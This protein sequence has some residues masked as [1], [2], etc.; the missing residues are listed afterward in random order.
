MSLKKI[1]LYDE[2]SIAE[3]NIQSLV[4]FLKKTIPVEVIVKDNFFS[5]FTSEQIYKISETRIF[6]I[7]KKFEYY[8]PN[9]CDLESE[10]KFCSNSK[11]M[12]ETMKP[13][14]ASSISD[15]V[16]YDGFEMQKIIRNQLAIDNQTLHIILTNRFTCT[17]DESDS[18]YH[19]RAVICANPAIIST[20]GIVEAPAK[21]KKFYIEAMA[22][23]AQGLDIEPIKDK[24]KGEY[25]EYHDKRLSKI[26][27]GYLLQVI[28][29]V[30]TGESFCD[31]LDCR[32]NNAHWQR[33][34]LYSQ[35][36][37]SKLCD[38]HQEIL[39]SQR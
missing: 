33:D 9:G 16:M 1:I 30:L 3:I 23:K 7:N 17:F 13:E 24:H 18:R 37:I 14:D 8:V 39:D 31:Y 36:E 34:L 29:Y 11:A 20:T 26:I 19:G 38:R 35:I 4:S 5:K 6:D 10:K 21:S 12:E 2:P 22:S 28:F 15:V 27:E 32:L 25:L